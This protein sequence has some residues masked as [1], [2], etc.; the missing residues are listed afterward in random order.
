[1]HAFGTEVMS[2]NM[3]TDEDAG[4]VDPVGA[5]IG[6]TR[7]AN[8]WATKTD[9]HI[10]MWSG[11]AWTDL[12]VPLAGCTIVVNGFNAARPGGSFGTFDQAVLRWD[13]AAWLLHGANAQVRIVTSATDLGMAGQ[14]WAGNYS[15]WSR[16]DGLPVSSSGE[17]NLVSFDASGMPQDSG[18]SAA[19]F[20]STT[21]PT[22]IFTDQRDNGTNGGKGIATKWMAR[23]LTHERVNTDPTN[24]VLQRFAI[25][26]VD[27]AN[28]R[29]ILAGD[30][31]DHFI[32]GHYVSVRGSVNN[33]WEGVGDA[34]EP[35]L[36]SGVTYNAP[37]TAIEVVEDIPD[38]A[39]A[40]GYLY[41][42]RIEL[43]AATY[44]ITVTAEHCQ[45]KTAVARL[46]E[47]FDFTYTQGAVNAEGAGIITSEQG[48][49]S[50]VATSE[51]TNAHCHVH[52]IRQLTTGFEEYWEVQQ[53]IEDATN[54]PTSLL[55][56]AASTGMAEQY[57]TVT[58]RRIG[59]AA[60]PN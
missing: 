40:L 20:A 52:T 54:N 49:T 6:D 32:A 16:V 30:Q 17:D 29:F 41:T 50:Y 3:L 2:F 34:T 8:N 42:G 28:D 9:G 37:N 59:S 36:I 57:C 11:A 12:G 26:S 55:G 4:R 60:P 38:D 39:A 22:A 51:S 14:I 43:K 21:V 23:M 44:E 15:G 47:R 18:Y 10:Y 53:H 58:V 33:D 31:T 46:A 27:K 13:G 56:L 7:I 19:D 1:M 48:T 25:S 5:F 24:I 45:G 35:Y